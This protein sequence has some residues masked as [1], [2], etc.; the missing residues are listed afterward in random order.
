MHNSII[1][2]YP[3]VTH[4]RKIPGSLRF[5][6]LQVMESWVAP[7][8]K[9][10]TS[11]V[12]KNYCINHGRA[13]LLNDL[14][15]SCVTTLSSAH[16]SAHVNICK[17]TRNQMK[18]PQYCREMLFRCVVVHML[19]TLVATYKYFLIRA[20]IAVGIYLKSKSHTVDT[21][22]KHFSTILRTLHL[23]PSVFTYVYVCTIKTPEMR[24]PL[25]FMKRTGS[26]VS[27]VPEQY[28]IHSIIQTLI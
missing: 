17:Y 12:R 10:T 25:H 9:A 6:V 16:S 19:Q 7:G 11:L 1:S 18:C 24:K 15:M 28:K 3:D 8:N 13:T 26:P 20:H 21:P 5:S 14:I 27:T 23:V 22:E 2:T 4:V